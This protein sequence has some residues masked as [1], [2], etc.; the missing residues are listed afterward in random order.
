MIARFLRDESGTTALE[1][2]VIGG[3]ISVAILAAIQP[4]GLALAD[5]FDQAEAGFTPAAS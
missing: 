4:I 2:A 1:Y 5:I 3:L